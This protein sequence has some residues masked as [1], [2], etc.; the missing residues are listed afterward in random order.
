MCKI[1]GHILTMRKINPKFLR[2]FLLAIFISLLAP[3]AVANNTFHGGPDITPRMALLVFQLGVIF[4]SACIGSYIFTKFKMSSI[5]GE[6]LSGVIIGPYLLGHLPFIGFPAG[7]FPIQTGWLPVSGE[8][9]GFTAMAAILLLFL[10]GLETDLDT[11]LSFSVTGLIVGLGGALFSFFIGDLTVVFLSKYFFNTSYSFT[12]PV[13]L[14]IGIITTATSVS[15][16]AN[17]LSEKR[18]IS[19]PE[20]VT[21]LSAA[22]IDDI[23]GI[24]ML[25]IVLAIVK[26]GGHNDLQAIGIISFR[27]IAFWLVFTF[28]GITISRH[29]AK[30]L[31]KFQDNTIIA[32]LGLAVCFLVAGIFEKCGLAMIVGAYTTGLAFSKTDLALVIKEKI[33]VLYKFF[34]PMFFCVMGMFVNIQDL[35]NPPII[36]FGLIYFFI[37]VLTKIIGCGLPAL[38]LNF[39]TLGAIRIGVGMV[40]RGEVALIITTIGLAGGFIPDEIFSVAVIMT[41][42]TTFITP[43]IL[44][45]LLDKNKSGLRKDLSNKNIANQIVYDMP[46]PDTLAL[47]L[48]KIAGDFEKEGFYVYNIPSE[49]NALYQIRKNDIFITM[50]GTSKSIIFDCEET[51]VP[52]INTV[53]FEVFSELEN[54]IKNIEILINN[55]NISP[56]FTNRSAQLKYPVKTFLKSI[57][58]SAVESNLTATTKEEVLFELTDIILSS[59]Q[60]NRSERDTIIKDLLKRESK[61]STGM[62][63]GIAFPHAKTNAVKKLTAAVGI[64]KKGIN[65]NSLDKKLSNIFVIVLAPRGNPEGYLKFMSEASIFLMDEEKRKKIIS[66]KNNMELYKIFT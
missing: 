29:V 4:F 50:T 53:M 63:E 66:A 35:L 38:L 32:V 48:S 8:L 46:D 31:K 54:V 36:T 30:L 43:P 6:L 21:I 16:S 41:F 62:Q 25:G 22:V 28:I 58:P 1:K 10:V 17:M 57:K 33:S 55:K 61:M 39:N 5:L 64:S 40:P 13:A 60:I 37:S 3:F 59:G 11:F 24:I 44:N 18:K 42:F 15:I 52:F 7:M 9:Y 65:F 12:H 56:A 49:D 2:C 47:I 51:Y 27:I 19:S 23:L 34:M 26:A 45:F 14:F 20:G